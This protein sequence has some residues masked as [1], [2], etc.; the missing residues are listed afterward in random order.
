[1]KRYYPY[2]KLKVDR[3]WSERVR[4]EF[5]TLRNSLGLCVSAS[6]I[7]SDKKTALNASLNF[8]TNNNLHGVFLP[9][10]YTNDK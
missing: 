4:W 8:I 3:K 9:M 2:L 1:M 10:A 7:G 6:H 5:Y